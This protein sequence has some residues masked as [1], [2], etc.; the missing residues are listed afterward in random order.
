MVTKLFLYPD[1][2]LLEIPIRLC[3][4]HYKESVE[5]GVLSHPKEKGT[6]VQFKEPAAGLLE[7][8]ILLHVKG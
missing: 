4:N 5:R 1:P 6:R 8:V 3:F 7:S 2:P